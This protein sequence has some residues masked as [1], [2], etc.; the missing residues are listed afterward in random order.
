VGALQPRTI[1]EL[2]THRGYSYFAFCQ[3]VAQYQLTTRCFA[4][5]HWRGDEHAGF[6]SDD[7][8][9]S[10]AT[11]NSRYA[12]FSTLVREDFR[13]ATQHITDESV[14]LL[15]IDGRHFYEDVKQDFEDWRPKL[16]SRSIVLFHDTSVRTEGFGVYRLWEELARDRPSF[17]FFHGHGLGVL[18][19]GSEVPRQLQSFFTV[20]MDPKWAKWVE[21][22]YSRLG[23]TIEQKQVINDQLRAQK[24]LEHELQAMRASLSWRLT[25]PLRNAKALLARSG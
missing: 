7:V 15:H 17:A 4:V 24:N 25:A 23:D 1:V 16:S 18:G 8:Y 6:Y 13:S 2:G 20:A 3:A 10:V 14:D 19:F 12:G 5:D 21:T 22:T 11:Q 9:Q